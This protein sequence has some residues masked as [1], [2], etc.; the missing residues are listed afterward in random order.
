MH[1]LHGKRWQSRNWI[2]LLCQLLIWIHDSEH[3]KYTYGNQ[4]LLISRLYKW[5]ICAK[6]WQTWILKSFPD[7]NLPFKAQAILSMP[8]CN[9]ENAATLSLK[10]QKHFQAWMMVILDTQVQEWT[11]HFNADSDWNSAMAISGQTAFQLG[12]EYPKTLICS[13]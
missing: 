10:F 9:P 11:L 1:C 5:E 8:L 2:Q 13:Q 6:T 7:L 12:E 4:N 3:F